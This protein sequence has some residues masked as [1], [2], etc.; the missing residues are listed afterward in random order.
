MV[1]MGTAHPT[2]GT[3]LD[4]EAR[5]D[6]REMEKIGSGEGLNIFVQLHGKGPAQRHHIGKGKPIEVPQEEQDQTDGRVLSDFIDWALTKADH[7]RHDYSM[8]VLWG[9]AF[10]FAVSHTLAPTRTE[11]LD[12]GE[13]A[14][15]LWRAKL[16][17]RLDGKHS[18]IGFD[19][20]EV[21]TIEV[22]NRLRN[23]AAYM[24]ASE[25]IVPEPGWPYDKVLDHLKRSRNGVLMKPENLGE[26]IVR[27]FCEDYAKK[28]SKSKTT[29]VSMTLLDLEKAGAVANAVE[30]LALGISTVAKKGDQ[31]EVT[32][33]GDLFQ[34]S[35]TAEKKPFIDVATLCF[36]LARHAE[37][38]EV[39]T[40]AIVLGDLL[41]RPG[42]AGEG[43]G[44]FIV[45]HGRNS[46]DTAILQGISLYAPSVALD[47]HDIGKAMDVYSVLANG[48]P[49][50]LLQEGQETAWSQVVYALAGATT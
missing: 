7:N 11:A 34:F 1:F 17:P 40:P 19:A 23:Y 24:V 35:Q 20:C 25:T 43:R 8:L 15:V 9:H 49:R 4:A 6:I 46:H 38:N 31:A 16:N 41:L 29:S 32:R 3:S 18:I 2:G 21:A 30:A 5:D 48:V 50:N 45:E 44:S 42:T 39:R 27:R 12:F 37:S 28:N 33:I 14:N 10:R 13:L 26:Y 36:H 47:S 22:A